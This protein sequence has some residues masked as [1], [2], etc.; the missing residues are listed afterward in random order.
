GS[1]PAVL[2]AVGVRERRLMAGD[3]LELQPSVAVLQRGEVAEQAVANALDRIH[4]GTARVLVAGRGGNVRAPTL[5]QVIETEDADTHVLLRGGAPEP[6]F[7]PLDRAPQLAAG[8]A[9]VLNR[10]P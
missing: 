8:I 1:R 2:V 6:R 10:I 3:L 9:H 5:V 7:V 4:E